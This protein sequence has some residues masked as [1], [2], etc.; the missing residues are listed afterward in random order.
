M[1]DRTEHESKRLAALC[2]YPLDGPPDE[3]IEAILRVVATLC[4]VPVAAV[5]IVGDGTVHILQAYG[6]PCGGDLPSGEAFCTYAIQGTEVFEVH[7]AAEDPRFAKTPLVAAG[8]RVRSY[9]GAPLLDADGFALGTLCALGTTPKTLTVAQRTTMRE[10]ASV[11]VRLL[12]AKREEAA[13]RA[14]EA[15]V[16]RVEA[17]LRVIID[18]L[19]AD[20]AYWGADLRNRVAN[21]RYLARFNIPAKD[22]RGMHIRDVI[23][24]RYA[25]TKARLERAVAGEALFLERTRTDEAGTDTHFQVSYVPH[26]EGGKPV[27]FVTFAVDVT[28]LKRAELALSAEREFLEA[29]LERI[30][31]TTVM[32]I[33]DELRAHRVYGSALFAAVGRS[34]EAYEGRLLSEFALPENRERL[35][36]A[37]RRSLAGQTVDLRIGLADRLLDVRFVPF[38]HKSEKPAAI[39]VTH[40]VTDAERLAAELRRHER[41][42]A[43]GMLASG[44]GHEINNPLTYIVTNLELVQDALEGACATAPT[45]SLREALEMITEARSGVEHIRKTVQG[46]RAFSHSRDAR[47][48]TDL[49]EAL[50]IAVD[51]TRHEVRMRAEIVRDVRPVPIVLADVGQLA[52]VIVNLLLNAAQCFDDSNPVANTVTVRTF[53]DARG[54][55]ALEVAD[56][57]PGIAPD[58]LPRVF[59]PFFTTKTVGKG[60]GLGLSICHGLVASLGGEIVCES[61]LGKGTTLRIAFPPMTSESVAPP[62]ATVT[63]VP[64]STARARVLVIDDDEAVARSVARS[65]GTDHDVT[66]FTDPRAALT[67]LQDGRSYDLV[68]CDLVMPHV[69]GMQLFEA[70][71]ERRPALASRFVFM[72]GGVIRPDLVAFLAGTDAPCLEKPF[73]T[74]KLRA[75][76]R[77]RLGEERA[78]AAL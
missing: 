14:A 27:G 47:E 22:I 76:V 3:S 6:L 37:C 9:T 38:H 71:T 52:Q 2:T 20:V 34:R 16:R 41:L 25:D 68:F 33:D 43:T 40:D 55:A 8:P 30:P 73:E 66:T 26:L 54:H 7:D 10:L 36:D 75:L 15:E 56:N 19:P 5:S 49:Q 4:E 70:A 57:G 31:N 74:R 67:E 28:P 50:R 78:R 13:R 72:T 42:A 61:E 60:S 77:E 69:N 12:Q 1:S 32:V 63:P 45:R 46:L 24:D 21:R 17:E 58:V 39:V 65:L 18:A 59:D 44:V 64:R 11:V 48:P 35:E 29:V 23:T 62:S 53:T 51:M